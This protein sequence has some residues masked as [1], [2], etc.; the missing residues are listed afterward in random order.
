MTQIQLP[1]LIREKIKDYLSFTEWRNKMSQVCIEYHDRFFYYDVD[2][3]DGFV[4]YR[5]RLFFTLYY[6]YRILGSPIFQK[7]KKFAYSGYV[8]N[9]GQKICELSPNY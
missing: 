2:G 7:Q 6:N 5:N 9:R 3:S 4:M 8:H 1:H